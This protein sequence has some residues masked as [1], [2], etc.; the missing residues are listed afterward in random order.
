MGIQPWAQVRLGF[1]RASLSPSLTGL[2]ASASVME[3]TAKDGDLT[4]LQPWAWWQDGHGAGA[5][6]APWGHIPA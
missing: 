6:L 4:R 1:L 3:S 5:Q 2:E